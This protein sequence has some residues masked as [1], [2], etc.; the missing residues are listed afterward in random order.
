MIDA[1]NSGAPAAPDAPRVPAPGVPEPSAVRG[2]GAQELAASGWGSPL[3]VLVTAFLVIE[4]VTGLWIYLAPFSVGSQMQVL[5]HTGAGVL[6]LG[7]YLYYQWKHFVAWFR[8]RL[9]AVM[10]LGYALALMVLVCSVSGVVLSWQAAFGPR[11]ENLWDLI[12]LVTGIAG[13]GLVLAHVLLA[14]LRRRLAAAHNAELGLAMR[15]FA[16]RTTAWLGG[17]ALLLVAATWAWPDAQVEMALPEGYTLPAYADASEEYRGSP[18]APTYARTESGLLINPEVLSHSASCGTSG[19][20]EQILAEWQ[21]SAHRFSAQNPPFQQVQK[22]FAADRTPAE[23]RY[24][25]GCHDPISLFAGAKDIQM[26]PG[27]SPRPASRRASSCVVVPQRSPQVDQRGNADYV[28]SQLRTK[29]LWEGTSEGWRKS[30]VGFPDP[31]LPAASTSPTTI[32]TSCVRPNSAVPAIS[33]S[34]P[35]R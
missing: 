35:R 15:R 3:T 23:T 34:S 32:A 30:A 2:R 18:F 11:L 26:Q 21:P 20:H 22:N 1:T 13:S 31:H 7:P 5:L 17:A 19:C 27:P 9:T 6:L 14:Y 12:H 29:Y 28:V 8:Q 4:S 33:S 10:V 25:A 16:W 24:C